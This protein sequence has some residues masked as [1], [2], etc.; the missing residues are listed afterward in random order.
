MSDDL[1]ERVA[2]AMWEAV[3]A[4]PN[5]FWADDFRAYECQAIAAIALVLEEAARVADENKHF[6]GFQVAAAIRA[7][8]PS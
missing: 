4:D 2:R 3:G 7:M 1:V 5:D 6:F 8:K